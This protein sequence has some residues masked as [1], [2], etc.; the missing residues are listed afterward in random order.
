MFDPNCVVAERE[1][2][3]EESGG[4][5]GPGLPAGGLD[6]EADLWSEVEEALSVGVGV[7]LPMVI[8]IELD[9]AVEILELVRMHRHCIH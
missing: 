4:R 1:R 9:V 6:V 5:P 3:K 7:G 8:P 2:L